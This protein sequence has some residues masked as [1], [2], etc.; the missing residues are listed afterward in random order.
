MPG[1]VASCGEPRWVLKISRTLVG[2]KDEKRPRR[3]CTA[4]RQWY[5]PAASAVRHQKSCSPECRGRR[6]RWTA[7]KRREAEIHEYRVA[8]R[9]RQRACRAAKRSKQTRSPEVSR[10]GPSPQVIELEEVVL[11]KWDK[12]IDASR[13]SLRRELRAILARTAGNAPIAGQA[14]GQ[15]PARP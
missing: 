13:A 10:A 7:R 9:E 1:D 2:M 11:E 4:C 6:R 5:R 8:E 14:V 12:L 15:T 3:R